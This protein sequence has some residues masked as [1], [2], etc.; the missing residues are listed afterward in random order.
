MKNCD[1][2]AKMLLFSG[3]DPHVASEHGSPALI[4]AA[5][6]DHSQVVKVMDCAECNSHV[7]HDVL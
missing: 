7:T 1:I 4:I 6:Y 3:A 2:L 5:R